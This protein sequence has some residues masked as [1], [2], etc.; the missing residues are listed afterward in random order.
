ML[1]AWLGASALALTVA[2]DSVVWRRA[3]WPELE[4]FLFNTV[5]NRSSEWGT[6]PWHWYFSAALPKALLPAAALL[7]PLG[8]WIERGRAARLIGPALL[9]VVA[10]APTLSQPSPPTLPRSL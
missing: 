8:L 2:I 10:C 6:S 4:V 3:L 9:F 7:L 5:E 1:S